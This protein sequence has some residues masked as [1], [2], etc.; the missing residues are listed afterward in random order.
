MDS[1]PKEVVRSSIL[2]VVA[3]AASMIMALANVV[4]LELYPT[5]AF[6]AMTVLLLALAGSFMENGQWSW[7]LTMG[8][9]LF[10]MVLGLGL[11]LA[12]IVD[13]WAMILILLFTALALVSSSTEKAKYWYLYDKL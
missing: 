2:I 8:M 7:E 9:G 5:V 4:A 3:A 12:E 13:P 6:L 1:R 11:I 10:T